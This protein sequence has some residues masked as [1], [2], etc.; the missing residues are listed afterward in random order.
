[1]VEMNFGENIFGRQRI[2]NISL[3]A[4]KVSKN[5]NLSQGLSDSNLY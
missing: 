2:I 4:L 1:M 3:Y 5:K